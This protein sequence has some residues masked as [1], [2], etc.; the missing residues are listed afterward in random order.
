MEVSSISTLNF[1]K[2]FENS[3]ILIMIT[4]VKPQ[5]WIFTDEFIKSLKNCYNKHRLIKS[6]I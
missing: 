4:M 6:F 2:V 5:I 1:G 3:E